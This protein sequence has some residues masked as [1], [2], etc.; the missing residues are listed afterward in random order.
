M[1]K[2]ALFI[3]AICMATLLMGG[4]QE[5][6]QKMGETLQGF[7]SCSNVEDFQELANR[8]S[9]IARVET[10]EWLPLYYQAQC[11]IMIGFMDQQ[12]NE[13]RDSYLDKASAIIMQMK[14]MAPHEAEIEVLEA[15][16][17]TGS[18][19]VDPPARAMEYT[20]LIHAALNRALEIEPKHPRALFMRI[21]NEIGTARYF[22][23]DTAPLCEQARQL[24]AS[25][26]DYQPKSPIHPNWGKEDTEGIVNSCGQ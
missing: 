6:Y 26:D 18:L 20:P 19:V 22:G 21:S 2:T 15:F 5:Y 16:C 24:L 9:V 14:T 11:Y 10:G 13:V 25:W 8:F 3:T 17:L 12:S 4:Q 7:A 23:S 1:K